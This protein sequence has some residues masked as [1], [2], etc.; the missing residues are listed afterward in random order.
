MDSDLL[1]AERADAAAFA[2]SPEQS[3]PC[4]PNS[5][6]LTAVSEQTETDLP[7][8]E[9]ASSQQSTATTLPC[10]GPVDTQLLQ[11]LQLGDEWE[12]SFLDYRA[13]LQRRTSAKAS[14]QTEE[15]RKEGYSSNVATPDLRDLLELEE[16]GIA[17]TW[18][19][20]LDARVARIIIHERTAES[21]S[22]MQPD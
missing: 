19:R 13:D 9:Q 11:N 18:P 12:R 16:T 8:S 15:P 7:G 1:P 6:G 3:L 20:G 2:R 17:V 4:N 21:P 5:G 22:G 10:C 14:Q